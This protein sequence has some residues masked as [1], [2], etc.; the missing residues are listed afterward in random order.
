VVAIG[1]NDDRQKMPAP[2]IEQSG[3]RKWLILAVVGL[4]IVVG[5]AVVL[6]VGLSSGGGSA[7]GGAN[8]NIT[9]PL[10]STSLMPT[11]V[12]LTPEVQQQTLSP[13]AEPQ[14]CEQNS[15]CSNGRCGYE[16]YT[17]SAEA[18]CC[19]SG[20]KEYVSSFEHGGYPKQS[21]AYFCTSQS[22]GTG[23]PTNT[24]CGSNQCTSGV[25]V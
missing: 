10:D 1:G 4:L 2:D 5:V 16:S 25:C 7:D 12:P 8:D 14:L 20:E 15:D 23:C 17:G 22:P 21:S 18:I 6:G 11:T 19:P 3:R 24:L 9:T 13:T